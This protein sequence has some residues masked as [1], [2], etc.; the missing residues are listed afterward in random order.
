VRIGNLA[1]VEED[2]TAHTLDAILAGMKE[3][4]QIKELKKRAIEMRKIAGKYRRQFGREEQEQRKALLQEAKNLNREAREMENY[5]VQKVLDDAQVITCTLIGSMHEY[6]SGRE[7]ETVF[8]DEAGQAI[9]PAV[10]VPVQKAQRVIMAGDPMQLPPTV[11]SQEA[12]RKGLSKT[13]IEK[14][15][16]RQTHAVLLRTQ[17]RMHEEIMAFSNQSFYHGQLEA[18]PSVA[19]RTL[20]CSPQP[21]EFIDTAGCGF[22]EKEGPNNSSLTNEEEANLIL[23]HLQ[24]LRDS[25]VKHENIGIISPYR[26]QVDALRDSFAGDE[27][28]TVNTVDSFQGQERDIIYISM[29][30]SNAEGEIGFLKDYRRMNVA[31]T[32]A[33]M[34]LVI[35]GDSATLGNDKFYSEFLSWCENRGY[36]RSAWE[37]MY[38]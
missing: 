22:D 31:M 18:H 13:L 32:R 21:L 35:V 4:K 5:L 3:T 26:A 10:W 36:Y 30:R 11:K 9:E 25:G 2:T 38:T 24:S 27:W 7:F 33:R 1:R 19:Q 14:I 29:V 6:L 37:F 8:I 16:E 28:V 12:A 17:Y 23:R 15:I 20:V 34:K